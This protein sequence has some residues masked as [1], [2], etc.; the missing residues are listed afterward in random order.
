MAK[1]YEL[2]DPETGARRGNWDKSGINPVLRHHL[3]T[4]LREIGRSDSDIEGICNDLIHHDLTGLQSYYANMKAHAMINGYDE[5][6]YVRL[7]A[8]G[9]D[10]TIARRKQ[11]ADAGRE[12]AV[13]APAEGRGLARPVL[14]GALQRLRAWLR[15]AARP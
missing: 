15:P 1:I 8:K 14:R 4:K 6:G 7:I 13:S 9:Y 5:L 11:Y 3:S 12:T 10:E 2:N